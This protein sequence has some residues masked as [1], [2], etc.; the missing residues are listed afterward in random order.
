MGWLKGFMHYISSMSPNVLGSVI[1][2]IIVV[3]VV[4]LIRNTSSYFTRWR[5]KRVFGE[6]IL[7]E[8]SFHLVYAVLGLMQQKGSKRTYAY[9]KPGEEESG[10]YF[11]AEKAVS[12]CELRAAKY[13]A[14]VIGIEARHAPVLSPDYDL[15]SRID[16]SFAS[17]GGPESNLKTRDAIENEGNELIGF[18][19][20]K[21]YSRK[22]GRV[23]LPQ[24]KGFDYGLILKLHPTQFPERVWFVCAGFGEWGTSGAAY[25]LR[26]KWKEIY[27]YAKQKPFAMIVR[28]RNNQDESAVPVMKVKNPV[29]AE[30]YADTLEKQQSVEGENSPDSTASTPVEVTP[31]PSGSASNES[32]GNSEPFSTFLPDPLGAE[33]QNHKNSD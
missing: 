18:D 27:R 21:F 17:F 28:V 4:D 19:N 2:G 5:F 6:D 22:S 13:L 15:L 12:S 3:L 1:G 23:V 33:G 30:N 7:R 9:I 29:E 24:E 11:S 32:S 10:T 20:F 25:Y 14:E 26:H 8:S 16:I 31:T